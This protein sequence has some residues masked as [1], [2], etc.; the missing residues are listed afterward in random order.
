M[1]QPARASGPEAEADAGSADFDE[2]RRLLIGTDLERV[3]ALEDRLDNPEKRAEE[4]ARVLPA[5]LSTSKQKALREALEPVFEK[6]FENSVRKHPK[7][8]ADAIYPVM[9]PAIRKSIAASIAEFAETLNQIVEKSVS[10]RAIKWRVEALVTGKS[11][12]E[13]LLARSLLYSVEQVFLIHRKSGLLLQ[14]VSAQGSV[15]KDA[16]M[17][18]GMLTAIQDFFS[19]SFTEGGQDLETLDTGRYKLWIQY[20]PK[21]LVVG[22][23]SGT[24][25]AELTGVFRNAIDKVHEMYYAE[26]DRFRQDDVSIFDGAQPLLLACLLGQSGPKGKRRPWVLWGLIALILLLVTGSIWYRMKEQRRWDA[27]FSSLRQQPGI[28]ITNVEKKGSEYVVSGLKDP[29]APEPREN[30]VRFVW[31]PYLSLKTTF[32]T[33]REFL[34]A[35]EQL[36]SLQVRFDAGSSQL[37]SFEAWR[38]DQIAGAIAKVMKLRPGS[39]VVLTGRADEVGSPETNNK[40][41]IERSTRVRDALTA[42]GL[43][44][45]WLEVLSVGNSQPLRKGTSDWDRAANRSVSFLVR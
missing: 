3:A 38:I 6:A 26:L 40:L 25:P 32:A 22:A 23:V 9:G 10:I 27:Y 37:L 20:G 41:S 4:V 44:M 11:F 13:I 36:E 34:S 24:A 35:K 18:A 17:I 5:S 33:E 30:H 19:D 28:A 16:D 12:S 42:Q 7:E 31:Q 14:H 1:P 29:L 15:L 8:L 39:H 2:L 21:A 43:P 45:D